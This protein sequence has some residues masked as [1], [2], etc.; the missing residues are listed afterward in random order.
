[1]RIPQQ[2][3]YYFLHKI[4]RLRKYVAFSEASWERYA[5]DYHAS[6]GNDEL[7]VAAFGGSRYLSADLSNAFPQYHR[8]ASFLMLFALFEDDLNRVCE[9][10]A[11]DRK[12][13]PPQPGTKARGIERAKIWLKDIAGID[14]AG[15][16]EWVSI[17]EFRE[18]RNVLIHAAG[19]LNP[20]NSKHERVR[21]IAERATSR[22]ELYHYARTELTL[23][24][25]FLNVVIDTFAAIYQ[26]LSRLI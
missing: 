3:I 10:I 8:R 6:L 5:A 22:Y 26:A 23:R 11:A 19:F 7:N 25:G 13:N 20:A 2:H 24:S 12:L 21:K 4:G 9:V 14:I 18:V 17:V 1:M 15:T 16:H